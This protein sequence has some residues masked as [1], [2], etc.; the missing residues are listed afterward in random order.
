[1]TPDKGLTETIIKW[2][3]DGI[4]RTGPV[5]DD[6]YC[7]TFDMD[8]V[9]HLSA[10]DKKKMYDELT[11]YAREAKYYG[12]PNAGVGLIYPIH[13]SDIEFKV[14][15]N[16]PDEFWPKG[17]GMDPG[18][19]KTAVLWFAYC[20][21]TDTIYI[22]DEYSAGKENA[23]HHA[24]AIK[25]RGDWMIGVI[26]KAAVGNNSVVSIENAYDIY[27]D[28]GLN[29]I[30]SKAGREVEAGIVE[31]W[32]RLSTGKLKIASHLQ[33]IF[34]EFNLYRKDADGKIVSSRGRDGTG[35]DLLDSLRYIVRHFREIMQM[36]PDPWA[37]DKNE[38]R[39][40]GMD[41]VGGY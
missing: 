17:Y 10:E 9:P 12:R 22:Y 40:I 31:T 5:T 36:K 29:L 39:Y 38:N 34:S 23:T 27:R 6:S 37:K 35:H 15:Q 14:D 7:V 21:K 4:V 2:F 19:I 24:S 18:F 3:P 33:N 8:D 32:N 41:D 28:L 13:R 26:D 16:T 1:M 25:A 30:L 11:P 20:E